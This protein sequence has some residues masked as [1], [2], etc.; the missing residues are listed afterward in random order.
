MQFIVNNDE[1]EIKLPATTRTLAFNIHD[2]NHTLF[3]SIDPETNT[4]RVY[5]SNLDLTNHRANQFSH[6]E[7]QYFDVHFNMYL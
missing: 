2:T 7:M 4:V 5:K 1:T 3:V 6:G